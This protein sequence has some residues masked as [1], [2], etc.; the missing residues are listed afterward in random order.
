MCTFI[1]SYL[2]RTP[3]L[4]FAIR[5]IV[6]ISQLCIFSQIN[7]DLLIRINYTSCTYKKEN[8]FSLYCIS[9]NSE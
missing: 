5:F 7:A 2:I 9:G 1:C 8:K 4:L 6:S 3:G